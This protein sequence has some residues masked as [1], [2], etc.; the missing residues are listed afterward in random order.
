MLVLGLFLQILVDEF[1]L[2]VHLVSDEL[3][4]LSSEALEAGRI[5]CKKYLVKIFWKDFR[6]NCKGTPT[7]RMS[8]DFSE[9]SAVELAALLQVCRD[10]RINKIYPYFAHLH[11][12]NRTFYVM[13]KYSS[14]THL[15]TPSHAFT[16]QCF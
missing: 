3:E 7:S 2:C 10:F 5:C 13:Y 12:S 6:T 9:R 14:F 11:T 4:P 15:H 8:K 16:D 1:P